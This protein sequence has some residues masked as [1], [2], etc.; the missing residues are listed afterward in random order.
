M[1]G[2]MKFDTI[3]DTAALDAIAPE[4]TDLWQ[5]DERS[6]PFQS[7]HWLLPWWR[8]F[9]SDQLFAIAGRESGRLDAFA[10]LYILRDEDSDDTLGIFI[11]TGIT[12]YLDVLLAPGTPADGIVDA[13]T[14]DS[15]CAT[16]DL[17]QLRPASALLRAMT[18]PGWNVNTE[19]QDPCPVLP[20]EGAGDEMQNLFSTHF[21]KK[22]RYYRRSLERDAPVSFEQPTAQ[23]LDQ[24]VSALFELHAARWRQKDMPGML[25]DE[26][27]QRFH[28]DAA[29]RMFDAGALRMH[30]MRRGES[31]V[32]IFYGFAHHGTVYYYLSGYDPAL[33]RLSV[34]TVIVAHALEQAVREG[35][36]TFDFLRGGEEYKHAW[37]AVDRMNVRT[38]LVRVNR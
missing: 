19:D 13:M 18:P 7:P 3:A 33:E 26:F 22:L 25:A 16:W 4:W 28:R 38:Q 5:R 30:A 17:Q 14:G 10:P 15:G 2:R 32:A 31:I 36:H 29:R 1:P 12:D 37:G 20:I 8:T 27:I 23:T 6:T 34:G 35:A 24:F 21:R 11:G 9:G